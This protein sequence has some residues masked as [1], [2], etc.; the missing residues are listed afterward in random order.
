MEDISSAYGF[1]VQI[2]SFLRFGNIAKEGV[3]TGI[4]ATYSNKGESSKEGNLEQQIGK[5][6]QGLCLQMHRLR[7]L[8]LY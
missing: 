1:A 7:C 5:D 4:I 2:Y 3:L 6:L 8:H